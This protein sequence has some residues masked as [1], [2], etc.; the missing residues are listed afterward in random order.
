MRTPIL[1]D[2]NSSYQV[3]KFKIMQTIWGKKRVKRLSNEY[4]GR[5]K[6]STQNR[7]LSDEDTVALTYQPN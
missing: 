7:T 3:K 4:S 2:A 1:G 5:P 6:S